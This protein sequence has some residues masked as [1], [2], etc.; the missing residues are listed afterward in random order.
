MANAKYFRILAGFLALACFGTLTVLG[1]SSAPRR[2]TQAINDSKLVTLKGHVIPLANAT[3]DRGAVVDS[4]NLDHIQ[5][6]LQ[7]SPEQEAELEQLMNEQNDKNSPNFHKWLT[8]EDFGARFGVAQEDI[9]AITSWLESHGFTVNQVYPNHMLIDFSGTAGQMRTAFHT[10]IH[11]IDFNGEPHM[12][13]MAN[14]QIPDALAPV[15]TGFA[16]LHDIKPKP[17]HEPVTD[18]NFSGCTRTTGTS[19]CYAVTPQDNAAIYNLNPLY[20]AGFSGQGQ[21]IYLVED[22]NTYGATGTNGASDWNSYRTTF[23]LTANYPLGNYAMINPGCTSPGTNGDDGE[24]AID[25]EVASAIAPSANIRLISCAGSTFT[26]GGQVALQNLINAASGTYP[27]GV[28]S[29][30]YGLCEALTGQGGN[31][32]FSNT[33]QQASAEGYSVFVSSGDEGP[34]SCS[35]LFSGYSSG[36]DVAALGISGWG[37]SAYNVSVGG[38]DFEDS[39]N[40]KKANAAEGG[41]LIPEST[42]WNSTNSTYYGSAKGYIP[43]IP[44]NDACASALIA[45]VVAGTFTTYGTSGA[46]NN[47]LLDTTSTYLIPAAGSGGA[48]N[49]AIGAA[50]SA[51]TS[52]VESAPEC[53]GWPKPSWQSGT[54]LPG[55]VAVYGVPNDGVRDIPDVSMFAANGIWGH[56]EVVCWTDPTQTSGGATANCTGAPSTWAGFGGTSV[57][58]PTMAAVQALVNQRTGESWGNPNPTYYTIAQSEYGTR[59]GS[60]LGSA[61]NSSGSGGP[62]STCAFNDIT[63][64]DIDLAC[65]YNGTTEEAHCYKP[66]GTRGVDSTDVIASTSVINGGTG[67]TTA[68][69]CTIAGPT[70]NQPYLSPTGSTLYAGGV[71]ATCTASVTATSTTAVWT[72]AFGSTSVSGQTIVFADNSGNVLATYTVSG[73]GS[74]AATNLKNSINGGTFATATS[75]SSTVTATAKTAGYA[76]NFYVYWGFFE[77]PDYVTITNTTKGQGPNYVSGITITAAGSGYQ[78]ETPITFTGGGGSGAIAVANTAPGTASSSYQPS[79]GAAPGYDLATGLGSPNGYALVCSSAWGKIA[80]SISWSQQGAYTYGQSPVALTA[81][82]GGSGNAVT[83]TLVS[84]PGSI[85]GSTLTITGAGSIVINANQAG[86]CSYGAATQVQ[87]TIT[88][89]AA[90]VTATAGSYSGTYDGSTHALSA[91]VVTGAYTGTLT[92]TN[93]PAGP[94]GAGAGSGTVTPVAGGDTLSNYNITSNNGSWSIAKASSSVTINC[95]ASETY[96]GLAQTPCTASVTGAGGLSQSVTVNYSN[97]TNVGAATATA[98]FTGDA[99]HNGSNNSGG[100]AITKA[101]LTVTANNASRATGAANPTFTAS[102][103]GFV[104]GETTAVL[105][106]SPSLTT[107]ATTSSPAGL[108]PITAAQ[109]SLSAANYSFSFVNGTLSVVA[110]PATTVTPSSSITGSHAAGYILTITVQNPGTTPLTNLVLSAAT[111]GTTV[112]TPLPQVWGTLAAGATAT[113]TVNFPGSVGLDGAGVAEKYSGTYT[114]STF[115]TSIRSVTLP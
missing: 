98:A 58:A 23:G 35:N 93:S 38:T 5:L 112:G 66:S 25:V 49:C 2:V 79:Y 14:P 51:Q 57:A 53:Q 113:F 7:R 62:A 102:Y 40:S 89:N 9:D 71:Q 45:N 17:M 101:P 64:G 41:S 77:G 39:Y 68:P 22:T 19:T 37:D 74:T 86:N 65:E 42:Y 27:V 99:N 12:A 76:G 59:G 31:A 81:T 90:P 92:C 29:V 6:V 104:N 44:W 108:Y 83:Y 63:Q 67:Y 33:Y 87:Q 54:S 52:Y 94:V 84:G 46:C 73:S 30:S 50:G 26:F 47:S 107:T 18:Y 32:L 106:G 69:T 100:F 20:A 72:I 75:S 24:A 13:N 4:L 91:C 60:F 61:C 95:P 16:A 105:S 11:N 8:A 55:G 96:T 114:G 80:Q 21:T 3:T 28:V 103:S 34:S 88:V 97:N 85:S 43:E 48:S 1:Q 56:Y 78:P 36:Y 70:N 111:L 82:G 10:P 15:V 115:G 110:P 109:G